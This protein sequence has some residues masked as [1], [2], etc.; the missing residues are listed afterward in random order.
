MP[1]DDGLEVK[2]DSQVVFRGFDGVW[3]HYIRVCNLTAQPKDLWVT[4]WPYDDKLNKIGQK[5]GKRIASLAPNTCVWISIDIGGQPTQYY[6]DVY[7]YSDFWPSH[8]G[9]RY[10]Y[11]IDSARIV[12]IYPIYRDILFPRGVRITSVGC[13]LPYPRS[14]EP[15]GGSRRFYIRGVRGL[16]PGWRVRNLWPARGETFVLTPDQKE[17]PCTMELVCGRKL[18]PDPV[19]NITIEVG[20]RG[21]PFRPPYAVRVT[22]PFVR[23]ARAPV[24]TALR[25]R[26]VAGRPEHRFVA[27]VRDKLG[28]LEAPELR[29]STNDGR[30]WKTAIMQLDEIRAATALGAS[31]AVFSASAPLPSLEA[32]VLA[33]VRCPDRLGYATESPVRT[34]GG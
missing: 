14:L 34:Y 23:K 17:F 11:V 1:N 25:A 2:I 31:D 3:K 28:L 4:T 5:T 20:V 19:T 18:P 32:R 9:G 15:D 22:I 16:P 12:D 21:K 8:E 7:E 13:A 6:T 33:K 27:H 30:T 24:L 26:R 29:Y 10:H